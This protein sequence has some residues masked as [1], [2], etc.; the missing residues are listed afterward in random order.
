MRNVLLP[1]Q[2]FAVDLEV[3]LPFGNRVVA[4]DVDVS[5][6]SLQAIGVG[7]T[8]SAVGGNKQVDGFA[9]I[10]RNERSISARFSPGSEI[11]IEVAGVSEAAG[12]SLR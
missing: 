2:R 12:W 10:L 8:G 1:E 6:Q 11:R 3:D 4:C 7:E 5:P 9:A